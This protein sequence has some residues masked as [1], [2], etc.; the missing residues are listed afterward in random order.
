V[1]VGGTED[2]SVAGKIV[3]VAVGRLHNEVHP[4]NKHVPI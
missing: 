3:K 1:E 2:N 4:T